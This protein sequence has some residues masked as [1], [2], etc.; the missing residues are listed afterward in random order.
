MSL[1]GW[2]KGNRLVDVTEQDP[3]PVQQ[4]GAIAMR[5]ADTL[6]AITQFVPT[7]GRTLLTDLQVGDTDLYGSTASEQP[8]LV[9]TGKY[10]GI[11]VFLAFTTSD[12]Y[13]YRVYGRATDPNGEPFVSG[14]AV[15]KEGTFTSVPANGRARIDIG[16][17]NPQEAYYDQY[18]IVV[19]RASSGTADT[20]AKVIGVR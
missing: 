18:R 8:T 19:A 4:Q 16:Y 9:G 6:I 12:T 11:T 1:I 20:Y 2:L 3:L 10:R 17:T 14:W 7:T 5:T 13:H 15:V